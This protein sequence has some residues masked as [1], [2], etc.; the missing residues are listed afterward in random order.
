MQIGLA[1]IREGRGGMGDL[2]YL[3]ELGTTMKKMS[4]CGLGQTAGNPV[5]SSL[6]SFR[7]EYLKRL[8]LANE[9]L[10]PTFDMTKALQAAESIAKRRSSY[11]RG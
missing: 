9:D 8:D 5:L 2:D 3:Q 10:A 4:R 1:K 6:R 11:V 7:E